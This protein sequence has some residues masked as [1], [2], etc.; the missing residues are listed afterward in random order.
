MD[1]QFAEQPAEI[2]VLLDGHFLVA[3]EDDQV[4]HQRVVD[5]LEGLIAERLRE[6]DPADLGA[7]ARRQRLDLDR[8]VS[9]RMRP[10][11]VA[12]VPLV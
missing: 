8:L 3:E 6:V 5:F 9:H 7:D 12:F 2:L 11:P 1:V 4:V 10:S